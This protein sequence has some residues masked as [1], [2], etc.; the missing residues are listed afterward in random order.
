[1]ARFLSLDTLPRTHSP[2][3]HFCRL[4]DAAGLC[5]K[6][7]STLGLSAHLSGTVSTTF[8]VIRK[9]C[10]SYRCLPSTVAST[11]I[12]QSNISTVL[13]SDIAFFVPLL[14]SHQPAVHPTSRALCLHHVVDVLD[15]QSEYQAL[16]PIL[17]SVKCHCA[18]QF[19]CD[20]HTSGL[21]AASAA[22]LRGSW[23]AAYMYAA[24]C[25]SSSESQK[26]PVSIG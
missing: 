8:C 7:N 6:A 26:S 20:Q 22:F 9:P 21:S 13:C 3:V 24:R 16:C 18:Q 15:Q 12:C 17:W 1:M 23:K 10:F 4:V 11:H 5:I 19:G 25:F 14:P 2:L